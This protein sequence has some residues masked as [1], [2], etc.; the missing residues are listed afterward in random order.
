MFKTNVAYSQTV[1]PDGNGTN[2][3]FRLPSNYD[4]A[5]QTNGINCWQQLRN[6]LFETNSITN[7]RNFFYF[8]HG[9]SSC[10]CDD[11]GT[12][13]INTTDV[14][15]SLCL[16]DKRSRLYRFVFLFA[17]TSADGG[18]CEAFGIPNNCITEDDFRANGSRKRAF[19]GISGKYA[20]AT[21]NVIDTETCNFIRCFSEQWTD[22]SL[23]LWRALERARND[24][25]LNTNKFKQIKIQGYTN[26]FFNEQ[27]DTNIGH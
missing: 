21:N 27:N 7:P 4:P 18:F 17:C 15:S 20:I 24:S 8:G 3:T 26:L 12:N 5:Y 2:I 19:V 6:A 1:K 23:P 13:E 11:C 14:I 22:D 25:G 10:I 9:N 16:S